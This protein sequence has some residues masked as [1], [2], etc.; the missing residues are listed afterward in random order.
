MQSSTAEPTL[1]NRSDLEQARS[2]RY[3]RLAI[4]G[5]AFFFPIV[6]FLG[7]YLFFFAHLETDW[8]LRPSISDFHQSAHLRDV[9]VGIL[10]AIGVFLI[11]YLGPEKNQ[12]RLSGDDLWS[13]VAGVCMILIAL[14]PTTLWAWVHYLSA[15]VCFGTLAYFCLC[16]FTKTDTT[17]HATK[18][19][20]RILKAKERRNAFYRSCGYIII[21]CIVLIGVY[22]IWFEKSSLSQCCP[23]FWLESI[24]VWAFSLSWLIKGGAITKL[25]DPVI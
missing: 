13:T 19:D 4:G 22:K 7:T 17:T 25:N 5:L 24:C 6:L 11:A 23:V 16:L 15:A 21:A 12:K 18:K 9:F 10:V 8:H 2:Y 1:S 20:K 14:V 3:L